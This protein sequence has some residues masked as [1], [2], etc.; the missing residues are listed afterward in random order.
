MDD[1]FEKIIAR[2][3]SQ[4]E[5]VHNGLGCHRWL[6]TTK[7]GGMYGVIKLSVPGYKPCVKNVHRALYMC[8]YKNLHLPAA[9]DVSHICH[10]T[11]CVNIDHLVLESHVTNMERLECKNDG[12]CSMKHRPPCIFSG[13]HIII[14]SMCKY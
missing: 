2:I 3:K 13:K 1:F 6:G 5:F 9:L 14:F 10:M 4:S 12:K 11:K 7:Q 8:H